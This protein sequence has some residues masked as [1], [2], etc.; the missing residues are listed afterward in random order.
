LNIKYVSLSTNTVTLEIDEVPLQRF[1]VHN[2]F[3]EG[4]VQHTY[5]TTTRHISRSHV[6][7]TNVRS[8]QRQQNAD[9]TRRDGKLPCAEARVPLTTI[10]MIKPH[11]S[12]SLLHTAAAC[13]IVYLTALYQLNVDENI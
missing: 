10:F 13:F 1:A 7:Q 5:V 11:F 6:A 3:A 2:R 4:H 12:T 9:P 8:E